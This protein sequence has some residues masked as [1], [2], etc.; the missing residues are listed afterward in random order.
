M[1]I[2]RKYDIH[3]HIDNINLRAI[4]EKVLSTDSNILHIKDKNIKQAY[5]I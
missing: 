3:N 4:N 5:S 2:F 1:P